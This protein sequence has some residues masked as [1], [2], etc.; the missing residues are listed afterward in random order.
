MG[1]WVSGLRPL[2]IVLRE[3][4]E[5]GAG[6]REGGRSLS[7]HAAMERRTGVRRPEN[8]LGC[9]QPESH[10][11]NDF[12]RVLGE[13]DRSNTGPEAVIRHRARRERQRTGIG[14]AGEAAKGAARV[15][16]RGERVALTLRRRLSGCV[17]AGPTCAESA[18]HPC[19]H[20]S[21]HESGL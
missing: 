3:S 13:G 1:E 8:Q 14:A 7:P 19:P 11:L 4:L 6:A 18:L 12:G 10:L 16:R 9:S 15:Q 20:P 21:R 2:I 5:A 17:G